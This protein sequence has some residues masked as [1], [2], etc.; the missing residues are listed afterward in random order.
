M[1]GPSL[2]GLER[3]ERPASYSWALPLSTMVH[4]LRGN[5]WGASA[6]S[7]LS[8]RGVL[9]QRKR[10]FGRVALGGGGCE[11]ETESPPS[12]R[13]WRSGLGWEIE[14]A[15]YLVAPWRKALTSHVKAPFQ[16]EDMSNWHGCF[17]I[18]TEHKVRILHP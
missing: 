7:L 15:A 4:R 14:G 17:I 6:T 18:L 8:L 16:A 5:A 12:P 9:T 3:P 10:E 13:L 1:G 2:A 11:M